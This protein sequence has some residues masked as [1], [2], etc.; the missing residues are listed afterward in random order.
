MNINKVSKR[1]VVKLKV[2]GTMVVKKK[3]IGL[4]SK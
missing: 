2:D 4:K 1:N 3:K